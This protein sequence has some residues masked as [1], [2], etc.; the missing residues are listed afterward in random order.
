[1]AQREAKTS[2][3]CLV[4]W[5][6]ACAWCAREEELLQEVQAMRSSAAK[7]KADKD[8]LQ[9]SL[10]VAQQRIIDSAV[11]SSKLRLEYALGTNARSAA[12]SDENACPNSEG[13]LLPTT[14][15][16]GAVVPGRTPVKAFGACATGKDGPAG[17]LRVLEAEL[18][19]A[20]QRLEQQQHEIDDLNA[21]LSAAGADGHRPVACVDTSA[22]LV[23]Q[24]AKLCNV[25]MTDACAALTALSTHA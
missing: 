11:A 2:D 21:R 4:L 5:F 15:R 6:C 23:A 16:A 12:F 1:M 20:R 22:P 8:T 17:T 10:D 19:G 18:V 3:S 13:H 9:S 14:P 25:S 7:L 24:V